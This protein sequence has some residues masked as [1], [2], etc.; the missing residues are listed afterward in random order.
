MTKSGIYKITN[1]VTGKFYIGSSKDID[2]R[3]A[4]H[5]MMLNNNKHVNVILQRSWNKHGREK[6][7]FTVLEECRPE[8]CIERDKKRSPRVGEVVIRSMY[9]K[10]IYLFENEN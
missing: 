4:E 9:N 5:K 1:E 8:Q 6:F 3:I 10:Y 7:S 2:Q